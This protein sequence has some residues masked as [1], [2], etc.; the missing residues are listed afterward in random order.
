MD[1]AYWFIGRFFRLY[2]LKLK[3]YVFILLYFKIL[4]SNCI[5]ASS[6][7]SG[8]EWEVVLLSTLSVILEECSINKHWCLA[9]AVKM[10]DELIKS[11]EN[12]KILTSDT[13]LIIKIISHVAAYFDGEE[14]TLTKKLLHFIFQSLLKMSFENSQVSLIY[15]YYVI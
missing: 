9:L 8:K 10:F 6:Q 13:F 1:E 15:I 5:L 3:V 11:C 7:R 12:T 14:L 2:V 4:Y